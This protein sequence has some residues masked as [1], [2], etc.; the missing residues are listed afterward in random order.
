MYIYLYIYRY[1]YTYTCFFGYVYKASVKA[2]S[3]VGGF[4]TP[5]ESPLHIGAG[6]GVE[7]Q[8]LSR[9]TALG[10]QTTVGTPRQLLFSIEYPHRG[11]SRQLGDTNER[12]CLEGSLV[13][14]LF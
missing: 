8:S 9:A 6:K 2:F 7:L 14:I 4:S 1:V 5:V 3:G 11:V 10:K 13:S 12:K